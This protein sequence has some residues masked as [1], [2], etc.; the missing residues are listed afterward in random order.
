[1]PPTVLVNL[2]SLPDEVE[3]RF[4]GKYLIL[5]DTHADVIVDFIADAIR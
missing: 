4:V 2:P 5:R 1:M 3:F